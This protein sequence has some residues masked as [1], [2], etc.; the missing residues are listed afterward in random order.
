MQIY[1]VILSKYISI[2]FIIPN[3]AENPYIT[4]TTRCFFELLGTLFAN[5]EK[6]M[7]FTFRKLKLR[8]H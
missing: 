4:S 8:L 2:M 1:Y 5:C 6:A 3:S 7:R